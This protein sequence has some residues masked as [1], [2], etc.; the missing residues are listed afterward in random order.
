VERIVIGV[1]GS[2]GS[3][4]A[5]AEGI[6]LARRLGAQTV[7]VAVRSPVSTLG[8]AFYQRKLT[9][10]LKR[11]REAVDP[12]VAEAVRLGVPAECEIVEGDPA[13]ELLRAARY[14]DAGMIVVGSRGL[15]AFAGVLLGS[16]SR[17]LVQ[18]SAIPVLV[19]H[20]EHHAHIGARERELV[21]T[22]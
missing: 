11:T 6:E 16:V 10:Q 7:F 8:D 13:R 20:D 19:V 18:H 22:A 9:A 5:A 2:P 4:A 17:W 21:G 1:D 14:A 12:A 15:G 3:C